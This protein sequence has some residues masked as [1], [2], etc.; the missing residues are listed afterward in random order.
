VAVLVG[1]RE[2]AR[3]QKSACHNSLH[4]NEEIRT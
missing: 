4:G 3:A 1:G 2:P